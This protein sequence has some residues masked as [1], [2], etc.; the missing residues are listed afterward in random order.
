M[1]A[2][3]AARAQITGSGSKAK[4]RKAVLKGLRLLPPPRDKAAIKVAL[5]VRDLVTGR[6]VPEPTRASSSAPPAPG[7]SVVRPPTGLPK[8]APLPADR[9]WLLPEGIEGSGTRV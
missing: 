2:T 8:P 5:A 6:P 3:P 7:A 9:K 4:L 1:S